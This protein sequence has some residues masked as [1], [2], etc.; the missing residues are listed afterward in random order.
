MKS[1]LL[2]ACLAASLGA[3]LLAQAAGNAVAGKSKAEECAVCHGDRGEG[4]EG[5]KIS[6]KAESDFLQAMRDYK[7]GKR[8]DPVMKDIVSKL[9]DQ[10]LADLAAYY[11]SMK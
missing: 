1:L 2:T 8:L 11:A 4:L 5:P 6:G 3:A 10:D 9:S 7:S